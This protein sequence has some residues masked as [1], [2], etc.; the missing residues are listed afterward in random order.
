MSETLIGVSACRPGEQVRYDGHRRNAFL[1]DE[2]ASHVRF[3]PVCPEPA[4]GIGASRE[5]MRLVRRGDGVRVWDEGA[6]R[7]SRSGRGVIAQALV[8]ATPGLA[9]E[10]ERPSWRSSASARGSG[11]RTSDDRR[12]GACCAGA[13]ERPPQSRKPRRGVLRV[14]DGGSKRSL[15]ALTGRSAAAAAHDP[16]GAPAHRPSRDS[17]SALGP[18]AGRSRPRDRHHHVARGDRR[19]AARHHRRERDQSPPRPDRSRPCRVAARALRALPRRAARRSR[20]TSRS[21]TC[22]HTQAV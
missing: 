6:Q 2:L 9:I 10:E 15:S 14:E 18:P 17:R 16:R 20:S 7:R 19:S 8:D 13:T 21:S 3:V 12:R 5:T 11:K 4:I 1:L 22:P